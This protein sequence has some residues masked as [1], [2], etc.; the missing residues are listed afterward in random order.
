MYRILDLTDEKGLLCGR[1]LADLGLDVIKIEIAVH[2]F[3]GLAPYNGSQWFF[4]PF[5]RLHH[6]MS[7][8]RGC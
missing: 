8:G 2:K 7:Y 5:E 6:T 3:I 4:A 1:I